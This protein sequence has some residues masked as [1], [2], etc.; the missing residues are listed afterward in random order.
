MATI[1]PVSGYFSKC[2]PVLPGFDASTGESLPGLQVSTKHRVLSRMTVH[3]SRAP[4]VTASVRS[5]S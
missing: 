2:L 1:L 3:S 4:L 5:F